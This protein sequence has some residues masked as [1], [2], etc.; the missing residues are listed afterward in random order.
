MTSDHQVDKLR[1]PKDDPVTGATS[2]CDPARAGTLRRYLR[3]VLGDQALGDRLAAALETGAQGGC[4]AL[5]V[6]D[7]DAGR[8]PVWDADLIC[9]AMRRWRQMHASAAKPAPFTPA[10]I[11]QA[12]SPSANLT[13]Q[14]GILMD[15]FALSVAQTAAALDRSEG[16]ITVLLSAARAAAAAPLGRTVLIVEDDPLVAEDLS[17]M[18]REAGARAVMTAPDAEAAYATASAQRPDI[19]L[20]DYDLGT[21]E[22]GDTV[23]A[24]LTETYDCVGIFVTGY[25]DRVLSGSQGEPAFVIA[26]PFKDSAIRAALAYAASADRPDVIAA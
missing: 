6:E 3:A 18:A 1:P 20:C 13:R 25:P 12:V 4:G 22:N 16:E 26:K 5:S 11:A 2:G 23:L 21:G 10:A 24:T 14:A 17:H 19:A 8:T 7:T 15:V 9:G